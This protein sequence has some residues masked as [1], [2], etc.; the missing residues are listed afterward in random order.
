MV[1]SKCKKKE[2]EN[3]TIII[4][5]LAAKEKMKKTKAVGDQTLAQN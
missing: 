1:N 3:K 5:I 4:E 2:L